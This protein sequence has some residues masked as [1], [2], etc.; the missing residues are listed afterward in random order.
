MR[1]AGK[2]AWG[3][4]TQSEKS[5]REGVQEKGH[6]GQGGSVAWSKRIV[7][8]GHRE[9]DTQ[10]RG[11]QGRDMWSGRTNVEAADWDWRLKQRRPLLAGLA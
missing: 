3:R 5:A 7:G 6:L 8:K 9:K 1:G 11:P 4:G 10:R 2:G